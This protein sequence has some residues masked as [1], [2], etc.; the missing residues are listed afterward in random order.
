MD[1]AFEVL[2]RRTGN[3]ILLVD[4]DGDELTFFRHSI[5]SDDN[6]NASYT[7]Y[8]NGGDM[9]FSDNVFNSENSVFRTVVH[10]IAHNWDTAEEVNVRLPGQ[11]ATIIGGFQ[12]I[13]GWSNSPLLGQFFDGYD[14]SLDGNGHICPTRRFLATT[15]EP[16]RSK[17]LQR[18]PKNTSWNSMVAIKED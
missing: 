9:Y 5:Y 17:I 18:S 2:A 14:V 3:N 11:G 15:G 13:S 1:K 12:S 6:P 10:E 16:I 7:A 8:N 4:V